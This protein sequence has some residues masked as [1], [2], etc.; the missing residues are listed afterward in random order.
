MIYNYLYYKLIFTIN[1]DMEIEGLKIFCPLCGS[2]FT[3]LQT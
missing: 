3:P 1:M 2:Q